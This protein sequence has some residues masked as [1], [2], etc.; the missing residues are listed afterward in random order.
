MSFTIKLSVHQLVDFLLRRGDIDSRIFNRSAMNEGSKIHAS[1]QSK[2]GNEYI[3]EYPLKRTIKIDDFEF[4][5]EGRADGIIKKDNRYI[6]DEIKTTVVS[7]PVFRKEQIDWHL[8]Q[9]K[10]YAFMF[11]DEQK[12]SEIGIRL[13]YIRQG[14]SD[15]KL[16]DDYSFTYDELSI[17]VKK[18]LTEYLAFYQIILR[19][20]KERNDSIKELSFPFDRYRSGQRE[21]AK[22]A[23]S[24]GKKGGKLFVEAPTGIGKTMSTIYPFIKCIEQNSEGKIF[25]LTAKNSGKESAYNA[26]KILKNKGLSIYEIM[27]SAKDKICFSKGKGCNPDECP[28]TKGYYNKIQ[29]VIKNSLLKYSDFTYDTICKIAKENEVCPFE[30]E[31]DLSLFNDIIICDYNYM[32]DPLVYMKR[33]FDGDTSNFLVLVDEAHNLIDRSRDMYSASI[34]SKKYND[35]KKASRKI[36]NKKL[37]NS[38]KR[39]TKMFNEFR[40]TYPINENTI[41]SFDSKMFRVLDSFSLA[42]QDINKNDNKSMNPELLDFFLDVNKFIKIFDF[43]SERYISYIKVGQG[44]RGNVTLHLSCLDASSF[45]KR[46]LNSVKGSVLFSATLS[47]IDYYINLLGGDIEKD[48]YFLLKS[49]FPKENLRLLVAP[50]LSIRYS[51]REASYQEVAKYIEACISHR[52]GNYIIYAPSYEY[53]DKLLSYL[54]VPSDCELVVQ[55]K[56][57]TDQE[58][59]DFVNKFKP[60]PDNTT[61]GIAIIGGSFAEGI[62]LVSDRLIGAVIIGVGL[63]KINFES[64][65][66]AEYY[67]SKELPGKD[68]SYTYPGMNKVMQAVGRVIRSESDRGAVLLIDERYMQNQYRSLFRNEWDDYRVVLNVDDLNEEIKD[69]FNSKKKNNVIK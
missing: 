40:E 2:Q 5:I 69:F 57:M 34:S 47:P 67:R 45:L 61:I 31:L 16:I 28:F 21:L 41:A 12:L 48:S 54:N 3:S 20:D 30:L 62:D 38:L 7:L 13:T 66:I 11:A 23:Y 56:E 50:K 60:K 32:F 46:S 17:Y 37:K 25:Y 59:E 1:Y 65:K 26:I 10:C 15:E 6:I 58:K 68:Y 29:S 24:I 42:V 35:A 22:Y 55:T 19:K 63:P 36:D 4:I 27:I 51:E 33:Y 44:K 53:Q 8:G 9:A 52:I 49:P 18:L 14:V 64:D 43:Y 39:M